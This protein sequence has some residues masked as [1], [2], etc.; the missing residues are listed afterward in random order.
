MCQ[1]VACL[2]GE[3]FEEEISKRRIDPG[4]GFM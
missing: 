2:D 4:R 1:G 3:D